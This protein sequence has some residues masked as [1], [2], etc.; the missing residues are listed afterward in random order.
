MS[1]DTTTLACGGSGR[2]RS[3]TGV[4][5]CLLSASLVLQDVAKRRQHEIAKS[6]FGEIFCRACCGLAVPCRND[7]RRTS[8]DLPRGRYWYSEFA[9]VDELWMEAERA[10]N[11]RREPLCA[12]HA[13]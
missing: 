7:D 1:W 5:S 3:F 9:A 13:R 12:G 8:A 4:N 2:R 10:R 11:L 6:I